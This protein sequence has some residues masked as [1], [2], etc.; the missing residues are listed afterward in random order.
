MQT[1]NTLFIATLGNARARASRGREFLYRPVCR[2]RAGVAGLT[3]PL[4][5]ATHPSLGAPIRTASRRFCAG[6]SPDTLTYGTSAWVAH[7]ISRPSCS[8]IL[9]GI[10]MRHVRYDETKRL[11]DDL[12]SRPHRVELQQRRV[13][14]A[15]LHARQARA[16]AITSAN[17]ETAAA[18]L[19]ALAETC[20]GL[21]SHELGRTRGAGIDGHEVARSL[22]RAAVEAIARGNPS[23]NTFVAAG[24]LARRHD[25]R[26]IRGFIEREIGRWET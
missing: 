4:V 24:M 13:H 17:A 10:Q 21:R 14:A 20:A 23:P 3:S 12:E 26:G 6:A 19:P 16:L 15:A 8:R 25:A 5:L 1:A 9:A 22:S 7:R 18:D 11:Y 2:F